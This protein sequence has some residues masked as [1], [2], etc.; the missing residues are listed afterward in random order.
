MKLACEYFTLPG[1]VW[2]RYLA[3]CDFYARHFT[4]QDYQAILQASETLA[5][6]AQDELKTHPEEEGLNFPGSYPF[7]LT[8]HQVKSAEFATPSRLNFGQY[9]D[10]EI[11]ISDSVDEMLKAAWERYELSDVFGEPFSMQKL[12]FF[13]ELFHA[14][15]DQREPESLYHLSLRLGPIRRSLVPNCVEEIAAYLFSQHATGIPCHPYLI[16]RL[17]ASSEKGADDTDLFKLIA[18]LTDDMVDA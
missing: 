10:G 14:W 3:S 17:L 7:P 4:E 9:H 18:G 12:V 2:N 5:R 16:E 8:V 1:S 6:Q 11:L 15:C 13:H